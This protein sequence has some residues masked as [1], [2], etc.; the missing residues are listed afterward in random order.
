MAAAEVIVASHIFTLASGNLDDGEVERWWSWDISRDER[1]GLDCL[2]RLSILKMPVTLAL[3]FSLQ[4][5]FERDVLLAL[6]EP[7]AE[8]LA[9]YGIAAFPQ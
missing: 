2:P 6:G 5:Y 4:L 1:L 9:N 3:A 7:K 8:S